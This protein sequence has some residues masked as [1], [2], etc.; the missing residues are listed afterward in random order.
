MI[1]VEVNPAA[2]KRSTESLLNEFENRFWRVEPCGS[3]VTCNP[4]PENSDR[5]FLVLINMVE[6]PDISALLRDA[7]FTREG[8]VGYDQF[9][10]SD[11][12]SWRRGEDNILVTT[13]TGFA[14]SHRAATS[15]CTRFNLRSKAD[16]IAVF[17]AV[18][19]G[20]RYAE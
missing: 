3:R 16:R 6:E 13:R 15:L 19:Y 14:R 11:F 18:L 9:N 5:D 4:P 12:A 17:Q 2:L 10:N 7:G 1:G 8:G 20:N